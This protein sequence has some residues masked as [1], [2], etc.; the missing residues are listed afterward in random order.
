MTGKPKQVD[1]AKALED[2]A[3]ELPDIEFN[4]DGELAPGDTESDE[5]A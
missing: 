1:I 3:D 4:S 5:P 2:A